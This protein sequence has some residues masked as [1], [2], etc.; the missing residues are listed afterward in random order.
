MIG[1]ADH[2]DTFAAASGDD[3]VVGN[4]PVD[5]GTATSMTMFGN[6]IWFGPLLAF[7]AVGYTV[8]VVCVS[9]WG[10]IDTSLWVSIAAGWQR[11]PIGVCGFLMIATFARMFV[12]NGVTRRRL[13]DAATVSLV[14]F[15]L[16]SGVY[17]TVGFVIE[18]FVYDANDWPHMNDERNLTYGAIGYGTVLLTYTAAA[19]AHFV[20]GWLLGVLFNRDRDIVVAVLCVPLALVPAAV[21]ELL[22]TVVSG[23]GQIEALGDLMSMSLWVSTPITL[24]VIVGAVFVARRI[25]LDVVVK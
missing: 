9:I 7:V 16:L 20:S 17:I 21:C 12:V 18:R 19:A 3:I 14:L 13:G 23:G 5:L 1:T 8:V 22:L 2:S 15:S 24:A 6:L 11:W 25:T 4:D 10:E